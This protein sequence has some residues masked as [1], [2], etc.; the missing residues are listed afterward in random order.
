MDASGNV[1]VVDQGP[2]QQIQVFSSA[3]AFLRSFGAQYGVYSTSN[4]T[5]V[6]QTDPSKLDHPEGLAIDNAGNLY[7]ACN[8]PGDSWYGAG[9]GMALRKYN[10]TTT[11]SA[12]TLVWERNGLEAVDCA[13]PDPTTDGVDI[14]TKFHHYVMDYSKPAG[15]GWTYKGMLCDDFAY[16]ADPRLTQIEC[17][18]AWVRQIN[19]NRY[20]VV[21]DGSDQYL[22]FFR[23]QSNSEV[24][25][26]YATFTRETNRYGTPNNLAIWVDKAPY[27]GVVDGTETDSNGQP[28]GQQGGET[29]TW[30]I[31]ANGDVWSMG[32]TTGDNSPEE[33][34][35]YKMTPN[36]SGDPTWSSSNT[37]QFAVPTEFSG[38]PNNGVF[39]TRLF[40]IPSTD[41]MYV[42]GYTTLH[43]KPSGAIFGLVGTELLRYNN[44]RA[45][46]NS[47]KAPVFRIELPT[48]SATD[49]TRAFDLAGSLIA[50]ITAS[51]HRVSLWDANTG[52][53]ITGGQFVP[54]PEV[55]G[56]TGD[57]DF[58]HALA[59]YQ[60]KNGEYLIYVEEDAYQKGIVYRWNPWV[61]LDIG[62]VGVAG[63]SSYNASTDTFT[64]SGGGNGLTETSDAFHFLYRGM[65]GDG[66]I[67][68]YFSNL[69]GGSSLYSRAGFEIRNSLGTTDLFAAD[70][71]TSV[72]GDRV[73]FFARTTVGGMPSG[74]DPA[75]VPPVWLR[76]TRAGNVFSGYHSTDGVTWTQFGGSITVPMNTEVFVG[77][78]VSGD[79]TTSAA[80]A[81]LSS[82]T[83]TP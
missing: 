80:T 82:V 65:T 27:N 19:G 35:H 24:T 51:T 55:G 16:P 52:A 30:H 37:E 33:I 6:G 62:S 14:Y 49:G 4:G 75:M 12:S 71:S 26:P 22:N 11:P 38:A 61:D 2:N 25:V 21:H 53:A 18:G 67:T 23:F 48:V 39:V 73:G 41:T 83:T 46:G 10:S 1:Y 3:G 36:A 17:N 50:S 77:M 78:P 40:Y 43:P 13:S 79:S 29:Y 68:G 5:T 60:R 9:S 31:D 45:N 32:G 81:T 64:V 70:F 72:A 58:G 15:Q 42:S 66:S 34:W 28:L 57:I 8:G 54:G 20:L 56:V 44:W 59:L 63:S 76:V 74:N 7:V 47:Q 69:T